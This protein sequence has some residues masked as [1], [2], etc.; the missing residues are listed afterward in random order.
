MSCRESSSQRNLMLLIGSMEINLTRAAGFQPERHRSPQL[1]ALRMA[2]ACLFRRRKVEHASRLRPAS[3]TYALVYFP[4]PPQRATRFR[5]GVLAVLDHLHP[6]HEH[7]FHTGRVLM[8]F[9]KGGVI[10]DRRGIEHHHVGEHS[11]LEK[12]AVIESEIRRR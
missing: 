9:F 11:F 5:S 6:V 1:Y 12:S 8:R 3:Q 10:C 4:R 2:I 7:M